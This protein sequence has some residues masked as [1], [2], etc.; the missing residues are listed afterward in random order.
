MEEERDAVKQEQGGFPWPI[1]PCESDNSQGRGDSNHSNNILDEAVG[2]GARLE[3]E[4]FF[5]GMTR[6]QLAQNRRSEMFGIGQSS[7][8][9]HS[10][11]LGEMTVS[12]D[13]PDG[14]G[15]GAVLTSSGLL[16]NREEVAKAVT[17]TV[18]LLALYKP[19][20]T[21]DTQDNGQ[22]E[23]QTVTYKKVSFVYSDRAYVM[24]RSGNKVH[25][26]L[27]KVDERP[28]I[29]Q[30]VAHDD[31]EDDSVADSNLSDDRSLS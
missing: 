4:S 11:V 13:G 8:S 31:D 20:K 3:R 1:M 5:V 7:S 21:G 16:D 6:R 30:M 2:P 28:N 10:S 14:T 27:K 19:N 29:D 18:K 26:I 15:G 9:S 24:V 12:L 17:Q 25:V 22:E 23:K